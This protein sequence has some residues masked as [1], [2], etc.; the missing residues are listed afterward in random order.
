[1]VQLKS[2]NAYRIKETLMQDADTICYA[3][4]SERKP[5]VMCTS[6]SGYDKNCSSYVSKRFHNRTRSAPGDNLRNV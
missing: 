4:E 6:C 3:K 1:M 2:T 5:Y